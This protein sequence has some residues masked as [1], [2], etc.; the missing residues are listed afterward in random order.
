MSLAIFLTVAA[1]VVAVG[2]DNWRQVLRYDRQ[3]L[4]GGEWWRWISAHLV[5]SGWSHT[6]LNLAGL[7][8]VW[9]LF[10]PRLRGGAGLFITAVCILV[11]DTGFWFRDTQLGWYVG[12]S[13]LLHGYFVA[14]AWDET[15]KGV[16][17]GALL[18]MAVAAKLGYEQ[19]FGALPLTASGSGGPVWV[20]SHLYGAAGGLIAA[21]LLNLTTAFQPWYILK[22]HHNGDS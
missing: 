10:S 16:R 15:W 3:A 17:G 20:N 18:I 14:G 6:V 5:H 1:L 7:W 9:L 12:M 21:T 13:G 2:D 11:M 19:F 8:V 22:R 4:S